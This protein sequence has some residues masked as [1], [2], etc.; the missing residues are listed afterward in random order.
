MQNDDFINNKELILSNF[1]QYAWISDAK[2]HTQRHFLAFRE[3]RLDSFLTNHGKEAHFSPHCSNIKAI[4]GMWHGRKFK[5]FSVFTV[6]PSQIKLQTIQNR[7]SQIWEM[8]KDKY[9]KSLA[10]NQVC[11]TFHM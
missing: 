11:A 9:T 8:K 1:E 5:K 6:T 7:K 4:T 10:K 3:K 2:C